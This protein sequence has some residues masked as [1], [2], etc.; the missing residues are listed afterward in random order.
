M[1]CAKYGKLIEIKDLL[2]EKL[3]GLGAGEDVTVQFDFDPMNV[4]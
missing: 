1:K 4:M 3:Q 2:E